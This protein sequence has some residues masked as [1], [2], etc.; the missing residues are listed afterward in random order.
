MNEK[1]SVRFEMNREAYQKAKQ[2]IKSLGYST[3]SE[4]LRGKLI[5]LSKEEK[6]GGPNGA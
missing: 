3:V 2:S 1:T 5:E 4:F 6:I